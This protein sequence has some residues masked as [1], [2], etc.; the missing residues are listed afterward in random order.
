[1]VERKKLKAELLMVGARKAEM[2]YVIAQRQEE[3]DRMLKQI[4][5]QEAAEAAITEKLKALDE[6]GDING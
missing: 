1:M 4:E 5:I 3:I 2:E 6:K